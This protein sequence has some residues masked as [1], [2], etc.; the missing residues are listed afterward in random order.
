MTNH[1]SRPAPEDD[2]ATTPSNAESPS[3]R[4]PP[5]NAAHLCPPKKLTPHVLRHTAA[6]SLLHAGVD[7]RSSLYGSAMPTP[8]RPMLTCTPTSPS[9]RALERTTP[10]SSKPGR[11]KP[12]DRLLAFLESLVIIPTSPAPSGTTS[13]PAPAFSAWANDM[14]G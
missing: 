14:S 4:R 10:V 6:M 11:Y 13:P 7:T 3:T 12:P 1:C 2:S 5:S 8:A 9:Q